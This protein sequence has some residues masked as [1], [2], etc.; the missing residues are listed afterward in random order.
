MHRFYSVSAT[1]FL[2][3][4]RMCL[5]GL[6][7]TQTP[8]TLLS[9]VLANLCHNQEVTASHRFT[10][11]RPRKRTT[12]NTLCSTAPRNDVITKKNGGTE[13]LQ[14][15]NATETPMKGGVTLTI[16]VACCGILREGVL[17]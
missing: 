3:Q 12:M 2:L 6:G 4:E 16:A 10:G 11:R 1:S 7:G 15:T 14:K 17:L 13:K 5:L 9:Q 8:A